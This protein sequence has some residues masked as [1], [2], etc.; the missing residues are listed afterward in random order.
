MD[1]E[2][3]E[4]IQI[5]SSKTYV[6]EYEKEAFGQGAQGHIHQVVKVNNTPYGTWAIKLLHQSSVTLSQ[7]LSAL[8]EF[9]AANRLNTDG[10][11]CTPA[12]LLQSKLDHTLAIPMRRALAPDL[13]SGGGVPTNGSLAKRLAAAS[14]LA[15]CVRRLH[16]KGMVIGDLSHDNLIIDPKN[17]ALYLIDIDGAGFVWKERAYPVIADNSPKGEL[18]PP[19]FS[20]QS[21]TQEMDLWGLSTLLHFILT[22]E[23]PMSLFGLA[24]TYASS[25][26]ISWPPQKHPKYE[27]HLSVLESFGQP[28]KAAFI[29]SFN[30]GRLL[31]NQ[32]LRAYEW[33]S[34]LNEAQN[35]LYQCNCSPDKPFVA[36]SAPGQILYECP[37]CKN[38][39]MARP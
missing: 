26:T 2:K 16:E 30:Q 5:G 39:I 13:E 27:S 31:P 11:S 18:C 4:F 19:E 12:L 8:I 36:L 3:S 9:I 33:E 35:Y 17:W 10:L 21:Y 23:D 1:V 14:E 24:R 29:R 6:I 25:T 32:R 34:L 28:L 7:R 38:P 37:K 20:G 22:D 15:R